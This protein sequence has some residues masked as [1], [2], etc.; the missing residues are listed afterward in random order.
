VLRQALALA[1]VGL[2]AGLLA[3][4]ALRRL[5]AG[6][7]YGVAPSDPGTLAAVA[8]VL[9]GVALAAAYVPARRAARVDPADALR[10]E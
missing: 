5:V 1:A 3:A 6:M 8:L 2:G 4:L 7:L 9:L 10:C